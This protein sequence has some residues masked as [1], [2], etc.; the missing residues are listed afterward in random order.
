MNVARTAAE[1]LD[2]HTALELE[3]IDRMHLNVY[4]PVLQTGAEASY[5]FCQVRG[6]PN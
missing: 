1:V 3:C 4:A 2:D 5:S 6:N